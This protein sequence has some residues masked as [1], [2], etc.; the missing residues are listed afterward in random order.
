MA[1]SCAPPRSAAGHPVSAC[2]D[3]IDDVVS[4]LWGPS[5]APV[6]PSSVNDDGDDEMVP[7]G[8]LL[9]EIE[10]AD[11]EAELN[12]YEALARE[13]AALSRPPVDAVV[14]AVDELLVYAACVPRDLLC[15][16]FLRKIGAEY[17]IPVD[18]L[19]RDMRRAVRLALSGK[20]PSSEWAE[21]GKMLTGKHG[22]VTMRD[23]RP[24]FKRPC[25]QQCRWCS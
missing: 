17:G 2:P 4:D 25:A 24:A 21:I 11:R 20:P 19:D 9:R 18:E 16:T 7:L 10:L 12:A 3:P 13:V 23:G 14:K 8:L 1:P 22:G 5:V 15:T 6:Y